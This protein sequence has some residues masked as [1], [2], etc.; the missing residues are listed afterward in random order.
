MH[1]ISMTY[2]ALFIDS[3][4]RDETLR[5]PPPQKRAKSQPPTVP[6]RGVAEE[7]LTEP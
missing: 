1:T 5:S 6:F 7:V 3:S 2:F 4:V